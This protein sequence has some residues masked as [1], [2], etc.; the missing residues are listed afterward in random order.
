VNLGSREVKS[1]SSLLL[2]VLSSSLQHGER[3]VPD[4]PRAI[5]DN[6]LSLVLDG[7]HESALIVKEH[8]D[9]ADDKHASSV[10][11]PDCNTTQ[12]FDSAAGSV[13]VAAS[14]DLCFRFRRAVGALSL[15]WCL[16]SRPTLE[17]AG[18]M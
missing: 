8:T 2:S 7:Q 18:D 17:T 12:R 14:L 13:A 4:P 9:M 11:L 5:V 15:L 3:A 1:I 16:N 6:I 10:C